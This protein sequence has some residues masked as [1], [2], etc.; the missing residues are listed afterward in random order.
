MT[1]EEVKP[2]PKKVGLG[3]K[4]LIVITLLIVL[5]AFGGVVGMQQFIA[6]KKSEAAAN[7]P[8]SVS[9]VTAMEVATREWTPMISAVGS[10]RPN[11][12]AM[13]S[14]QVAGTVTSVNVKSGDRVKKGQL[15]VQVDSSAERANLKAT[16][17]QL[18]AAKANFERY[19]NLVNSDSASK[20]ELDNAQST[21]NQLLASI[22]ALKSQ[23]DRRQ[24]YA[25]F[26]GVAGIVNVNV[27]QFITAGTEI[28]RVEDQS[29]MRI[30][31]TLPQ[32]DLERISVGQRVTAEVDALPGQTFPARI[33]AMDP[34]VDRS[35][36]L[37]NLEATVEEG[38][39]KL[40]S[41]MFTRLNIALPSQKGQVVVPQISVAYTMY[42]ETVYVLQPLSD[43]D[44]AMVEKMKA[45]NPSLD[46][47]KMYRAKQV[48]VT[49][50]DRRGIYAQLS[51]GLKAGDLIVTGGLQRLSNNSLVMVSDVEA[52]GVTQPAKTNKL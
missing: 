41:G 36:G 48:E 7:M 38:A 32:T 35:T 12:G 44:K 2:A 1:T 8:E 49:T 15:L 6:G 11:Q 40:L 39:R 5:V 4:F 26:D 45:Q 29:K 23:I 3:R 30:R 43:E 21:Y 9:N 52:V 13:I 16:E 24:I 22:D 25:P 18:P 51:K 17:A 20:A 46:E 27:G 50:V 47:S 34:A 14:S 19:R 33:S 10:V 42:G 31:F 37:I 28:V